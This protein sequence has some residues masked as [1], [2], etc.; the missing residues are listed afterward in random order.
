[1][2]SQNKKCKEDNCSTIPCFNLPNEKN[3]VYCDKHKK[4][5][6]VNINKK[7]KEEHCNTIPCFNL[8]NE[9]LGIYCS[10]HKKENIPSRASSSSL[11]SHVLVTNC[12]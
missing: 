12:Y 5:N 2:I 8:Q 6:M 11:R 1:M 3:C 7:C 10:K 9:K 4:E